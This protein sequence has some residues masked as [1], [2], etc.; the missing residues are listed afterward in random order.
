MSTVESVSP[1]SSR[2]A[3]LVVLAGALILSAAMGIRQTFGLYLDPFALERGVPVGMLALAIALHNLV[4]GLTQPA[5]LV[6]G[7][8]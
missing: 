2:R 6:S 1:A 3:V 8:S 4:W 5:C 7:R